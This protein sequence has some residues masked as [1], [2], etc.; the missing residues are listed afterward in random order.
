VSVR[1]VGTDLLDCPRC[2]A[3]A[4]AN[5]DTLLSQPE[6]FLGEYCCGQVDSDG[7]CCAPACI[8]GT[9]LR[10][11]RAIRTAYGQ[12]HATDTEGREG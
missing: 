1:P 6:Q 11:I 5:L 7:V 8:R 12:E 9:A 4:G 2:Q 3:Q 10:L